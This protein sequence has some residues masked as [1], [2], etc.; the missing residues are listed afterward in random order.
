MSCMFCILMCLCFTYLINIP[1]CLMSSSAIGPSGR[2]RGEGATQS[3]P[4]HRNPKGGSGEHAHWGESSQLSLK[5]RLLPSGQNMPFML[6]NQKKYPHKKM[7]MCF[8]ST[9]IPTPPP[10]RRFQYSPQSHSHSRLQ[11]FKIYPL[12]ILASP[13]RLLC[14]KALLYC[15]VTGRTVQQHNSLKKAFE[16]L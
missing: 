8:S 9:S 15:C 1:L 11:S 16:E 10:P 4:L 7:W 2:E 6:L 13:L 3:K 14:V 5:N 12:I